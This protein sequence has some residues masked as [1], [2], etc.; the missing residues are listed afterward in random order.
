[1][2]LSVPSAQVCA[3]V[4]KPGV[5]SSLVPVGL[6]HWKLHFDPGGMTVSVWLL[7]TVRLSSFSVFYGIRCC[8]L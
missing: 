1:M 6:R 3:P 8:G 7:V 4:R 5:L 2:Q